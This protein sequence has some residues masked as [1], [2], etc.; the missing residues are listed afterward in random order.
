MAEL[1]AHKEPVSGT[2]RVIAWMQILE[3]VDI[4]NGI[5][6]LRALPLCHEAGTPISVSLGQVVPAFAEAWAEYVKGDLIKVHHGPRPTT[7]K[8]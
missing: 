2:Y 7:E 1:F 8:K 4:H 6:A 3:R 5:N